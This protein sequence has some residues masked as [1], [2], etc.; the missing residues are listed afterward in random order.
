MC[1]A[2]DLTNWPERQ[3]VHRAFTTRWT[4]GC[5]YTRLHWHIADDQQ[6]RGQIAA[7]AQLLDEVIPQ[8]GAKFVSIID[9]SALGP[10]PRGLLLDLVE[11]TRSM[12]RSPARRA[13]LVA[14]GRAGDNQA[15]TG[16]LVTAG[17]VR[18]FRPG[19]IGPV[20]DW[21]GQV[22]AIEVNRLLR[23]LS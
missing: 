1:I 10:I 4:Q 9:T 13:L 12:A 5:V 21:L 7:W 23:F 8:L 6:T 3:I 14:E 11:L 18:V 22:G 16:E 2:H 20:V 19:Q 17:S 15:E